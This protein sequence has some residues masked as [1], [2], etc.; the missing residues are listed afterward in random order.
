MKSFVADTSPYLA[1]EYATRWEFK[2]TEKSADAFGKVK[3]EKKRLNWR[4]HILR[5]HAH[6]LMSIPIFAW[7]KFWLYLMYDL[8][9]KWNINTSP[10][11]SPPDFDSHR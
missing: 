4:G 11:N 5:F 6:L 1:E 3:F 7:R 9:S 2:K 8:T 10:S